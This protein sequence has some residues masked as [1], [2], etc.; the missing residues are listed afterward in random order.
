MSNKVPGIWSVLLWSGAISSNPVLPGYYIEIALWGDFAYQ[1]IGIL[2]LSS[3]RWDMIFD[4]IKVSDRQEQLQ[5]LNL[6]FVDIIDALSFLILLNT[7][8]IP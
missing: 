8:C 5:L 7:L 2:G 6:P 1:Q 3:F 4:L